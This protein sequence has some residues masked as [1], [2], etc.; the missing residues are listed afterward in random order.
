VDAFAAAA[1]AA[2]AAAPGAGSAAAPYVP[3]PALL[4]ARPG[5][6]TRTVDNATLVRT[7]LRDASIATP[8]PLL[9][10]ITSNV[11]LGPGLNGSLPIRRPVLLLGLASVP[12]SVDF[13]MVVNQLN[14]T[15]P[16]A[17]LAWQR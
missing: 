10:R 15:A 3:L 11:T 17:Q 4:A 5:C 12:T 13:G 9:V 2:A 14:V 7:L 6:N 16:G 8:Q 1:A